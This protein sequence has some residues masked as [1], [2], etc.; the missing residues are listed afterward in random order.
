MKSE[1][2]SNVNGS[3]DDDVIL[4]SP[5]DELILHKP[6]DHKFDI[7]TGLVPFKTNVSVTY[8]VYLSVFKCMY[9]GGITTKKLFSVVFQ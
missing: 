9:R 6:N 1:N 2:G 3:E 5:L 8:S 4:M 7:L